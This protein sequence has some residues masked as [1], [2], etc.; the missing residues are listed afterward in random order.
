MYQLELRQIPAK[1][2][3][4]FSNVEYSLSKGKRQFLLLAGI[5]FVG[6]LILFM[7]TSW[8]TISTTRDEFGSSPV[9]AIPNYFEFTPENIIN[10]VLYWQ[11]PAYSFV[12]KVEYVLNVPLLIYGS[13]DSEYSMVTGA[14]QIGIGQLVSIISMSILLGVYT[15][16]WLLAKKSGCII[17]A[18]TKG[19]SGLAG[20]A[21]GASGI[22]S[23]LLLAGC[24][25][26]TGISFLL[27]SL[28]F[29]GSFFSGFYA[30]FDTMSAL[31][32]SIPSNLLLIGLIMFMANKQIA[33]PTVGVRTTKRIGVND[34]MKVAIYLA[35]PA[36]F[37]TT[38]VLAMYWWNFQAV[39][40]LKSGMTGGQQNTTIA[41]Y[42]TLPLS[43]SLFLMSAYVQLRRMFLQTKPIEVF[44]EAC[45]SVN[46][47]K[48]CGNL[49]VGSR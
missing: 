47:N 32:I 19:T 16:L 43:A 38:F 18:A 28:P 33:I 49:T 17:G 21:G 13:F 45:C 44:N 23:M 14:F 1:T 37:L 27:F 48:A 11:S 26:G 42:A 20:G 30:D 9:N 2:G 25:G 10:A 35:I 12:D 22:F 24:C 7:A 31:L 34:W 40:V 4:I 8:L 36:F 39:A 3:R 46:S 29:I 41:L 15:N 5:F 6:I